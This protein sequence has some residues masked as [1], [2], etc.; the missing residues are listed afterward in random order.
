MMA[1]DMNALWAGMKRYDET[2][3]NDIE[4]LAVESFGGM[5]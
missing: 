4:A 5:L 1:V 2:H 3:N